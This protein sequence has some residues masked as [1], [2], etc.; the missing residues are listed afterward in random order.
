M[1][2]VSKRAL[3][4]EA[5]HNSAPA[6]TVGLDLG[7]RFSRYCLVNAQ[8]EVVEEGR[9][10]SSEEAMRRH[11]EGQLRLRVALECGTHSPWVRIARAFSQ[12]MA[13]T[14]SSSISNVSTPSLAPR[15]MASMRCEGILPAGSL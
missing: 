10:R 4:M 7:D 2:K 5:K 15:R 14:L 9:I 11:F 6:M 13:L 1:R 3:Q 12:V 8:G